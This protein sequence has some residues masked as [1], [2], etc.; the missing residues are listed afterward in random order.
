[1]SEVEASANAAT[2]RMGLPMV[3]LFIAFIVLI[4]Y[5][6]VTLVIGGL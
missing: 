6:A 5:P 2:E 1:M 3:L 4:G